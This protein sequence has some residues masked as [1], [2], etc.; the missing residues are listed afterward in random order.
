M[1]AELRVSVCVEAAG[2]VVLREV[3]VPAGS[4]VADA[5][6][7]SGLEIEFPAIAGLPAGIFG[8]RRERDAGVRDGD[9]VEIYQPLSFDPMESRRR[10][11]AHKRR[12]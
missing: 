3:E 4:T 8:Q 12:G 11:A 2:R 7:A 9:R 1:V 6:A 10:R 5:I